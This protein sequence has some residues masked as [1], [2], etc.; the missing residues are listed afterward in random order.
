MGAIQ[1]IIIQVKKSPRHERSSAPPGI[2][3]D[4]QRVLAVGTHGVIN[5]KFAAEILS[6]EITPRFQES[7]LAIQRSLQYLKESRMGGDFLR[8]YAA[9]SGK[10]ANAPS[11]TVKASSILSTFIS[12]SA[13]LGAM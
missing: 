7:T 13:Y 11:I 1:S 4:Y 12:R 6:A 3:T 10:A 8:A 9:S 5:E 2:K